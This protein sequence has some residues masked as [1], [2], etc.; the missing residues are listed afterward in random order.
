MSQTASPGLGHNLAPKPTLAD[1][2]HETGVKRIIADEL[3]R[4]IVDPETGKEAPSIRERDPELTDSCKRFLQKYPKIE[5]D[6]VNETAAAILKACNR[7]AGDSG[8]VERAREV[9]KRPVLDAGKAI[10]GAFAKFGTQLGVR[11]LSGPMKD[12]RKA[13]YTLAETILNMSAVY[14]D[15]KAAKI[16]ES[17]QAEADAANE[18]ARLTEEMA[19]KGSGLVTFEDAA[20]AA[21]AADDHQRAADASLADRSRVKTE[22][23]TTSVKYKRIA[24]IIDPSLV[25]REYCIPSQSL[26]DAAK[27]AAG[28]SIPTIPGVTFADERD[29]NIR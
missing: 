13:P 24:T 21:S 8:R 16:Q 12:R 11:S 4:K 5:T 17:Q 7:F 27:G 10:D 29:M 1:L 23:A 15:E 14:G 3:D 18:R 22:I 2:L 19:T 26:I 6:E 20:N 9:L 25:P 28:S